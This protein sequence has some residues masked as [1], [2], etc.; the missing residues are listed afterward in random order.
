MNLFFQSLTNSVWWQICSTGS[1]VQRARRPRPSYLAS[2]VSGSLSSSNFKFQ[3]QAKQFSASFIPIALVW[4]SGICRLNY[5]SNLLTPYPSSLQSCC[6][7]VSYVRTKNDPFLRWGWVRFR[8]SLFKPRL[9]LPLLL[10]VKVR[11]PSMA[12]RS[13]SLLPACLSPPPTVLSLQSMLRT[14]VPGSYKGSWCI[15]SDF[16]KARNSMGDTPERAAITLTCL[17]TLADFWAL[18]SSVICPWKMLSWTPKF[19]QIEPREMK[20]ENSFYLRHSVPVTDAGND[21]S[22]KPQSMPAPG[23]S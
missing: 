4:V 9:Y 21:H 10:W 22:W 8:R 7:A 12:L 23:S 15:H 6:P 19:P 11:A 2:N 18:S 1:T 13:L 5:C 16:M 17:Q 3:P 14:V 20:P